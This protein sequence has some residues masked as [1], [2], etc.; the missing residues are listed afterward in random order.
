MLNLVLLEDTK[1]ILK[2]GKKYSGF[3]WDILHFFATLS[4]EKLNKISK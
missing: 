3:R 4:G 1:E 2:S